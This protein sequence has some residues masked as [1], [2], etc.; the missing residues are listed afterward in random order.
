MNKFSTKSQPK[1]R[2]EGPLTQ[3]PILGMV[4]DN[5]IFERDNKRELG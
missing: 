1:S 4:Q 3:W 5:A 2:V